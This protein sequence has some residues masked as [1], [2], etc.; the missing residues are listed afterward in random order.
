[1]RT[2]RLLLCLAGFCSI[3]LGGAPQRGVNGPPVQTPDVVPGDC[4]HDI[5]AVSVVWPRDTVALDTV[6]IPHAVIRNFGDQTENNFP[7]VFLIVSGSD[8]LYRA[9]DTVRSAFAPGATRSVTFPAWTARPE[10]NYTAV[11]FTR[12]AD[13][14]D[15]RNDTARACFRVRDCRHD[16]GATLILA[17]VGTVD[18]GTVHTP[19]AVVRNFTTSTETF[20]VTLT[21]DGSYSQTRQVSLPG[22]GVDT[23]EF[24][25]DWTAGPVGTLPVV[26]YTRLA[27]DNNRSND[28]ARA[29]VTVRAC[30]RHDVGTPEILW[31]R[32]PIDSGTV[33]TPRAV[34][35]NYGTSYEEFPVT[36]RIGIVYTRTIST[37]LAA[38]ATD[39]VAFPDWTAHPIGGHTTICYT[40]LGIDEDR[41]NDTAWGGVCVVPLGYH[42]VGTTAILAPAGTVDSGTLHYPTAIIHNYGTRGDSFP[43]TFEIEGGYSAT[44]RRTLLPGQ[45]DTVSFLPYWTARPLGTLA[46]RCYTALAGDANRANDTANGSVTVT[47]PEIHDVGAVLVIA[48]I[49]TV[50]SGSVIAPQALVRNWG[51]RD[52]SFPVTFDIGTGYSRTLQLDL[53][54]GAETTLVFP[55]WTAQPLGTHA[56][57]CYTQLANDVNRA[58]DTARA[59]VDVQTAPRHD[60]GAMTIIA[61]VGLVDSGSAHTPTAVLHNWGNRTENFPATFTLSTGYSQT[62][63]C[64]LEPGQTDTVIFPAWVAAIPGPHACTCYTALAA[65]VDRSNDTAAAAVEVRALP[66]PDVGCEVIL[67][68]TGLV[69]LGQTI[70]PRAIVRHYPDT[71]DATV[72]F[73]VTLTIGTAYR[74]SLVVTMPGGTGR[75]IAFPDWTAGPLG[76]HDV[77]CFTS[78]A[79]DPNR[80]NDTARTAVEV[81]TETH[82]DVGATA[83]LAPEGTLDSG[84][85]HT[86]QAIIRN[87]GTRDEAFPVTFR[88]G[89][90][91]SETLLRQLTPG[92][93]DTVNFPLWIAQPLGRHQTVCFTALD[94]DEDRSNDTVW[95]A[96]SV[97]V[98]RRPRH[99]V[100]ARAITAPSGTV[101]SGA[102]IAPAALVRNWGSEVDSFAVTFIIDT[103]YSRTLGLVLSPGAET[104]LV[105]PDWIA[106]PVDTLEAV[107]FTDLAT[108]EN[109]TNDTARATFEV[110]EPR[111]SDVGATRIVAPTGTVDS[112][113]V[114]SPTVVVRNWGNRNDDF[115]VTFIIGAAYRESLHVSLGRGDSAVVVFPFWIAGPIDSLGIVSYTALDR[116]E[117]R[118]NDTARSF[119]RVVRGERHD[120]GVTEIVAPKGTLDSGTVVSPR[121]VIHNWGYAADSFPVTLRIGGVYTQTRQAT[122]AAGASDTVDFPDWIAQPIGRFQTVA[123]TDLATDENRANDTA[124]GYD[125]VV[126]RAAAVHDVGAL[127]ITRPVGVVDSGRAVT[128]E[129]VIR[130]FGTRTETFPV[131]FTIG[132]GYADTIDCDLEPGETDTVIFE[133]WTADPPGDYGCVCYTALAGDT[134]RHN[135]TATATVTVSPL[136]RPDVG[137]RVILAP[138]GTV[139]LGA[140]VTPQAVV[141]HFVDTDERAEV[142]FPVIMTIGE[143]YRDSTTVTLPAGGIDTVA[144]RDWTAQTMGSFTEVCFTD[145]AGDPNRANDTARGTVEVVAVPYHDVGAEVILAPEGTVH[146][147][148]AIPPRAVVVNLGNQVETF[149]VTLS[150]GAEYQSTVFVESLGLGVYDT[151]TFA[152]W[153]APFTGV[154]AMLCY[155]SLPADENRSNDTVSGTVRVVNAD[156]AAIEIVVPAGT[157]DSGHVLT[158]RA[159]IRNNGPEAAAFP[160]T[161]RIGASWSGSVLADLGAGQSDTFSFPAWTAEPLGVQDAVVFTQLQGDPVPAND[162]ARSQFEVLPATHDVGT[163]AVLEP[164]GSAHLGGPPWRSAVT[165]RAR[166]TN[167]GPRTEALFPARF[168]IDRYEVRSGASPETVFVA[169][170]F[171]E[172]RDVA[173]LEP[174]ESR[175]LAFADTALGLGLYVASCSTRLTG[176]TDPSNDLARE[177]F[178][179]DDSLGTPEFAVRI[180]TRAGELIRQLGLTRQPGDPLW[181]TW[182]GCND[183][184]ERVAPGTYICLMSVQVA[185]G[186]PVETKHNVLVPRDAQ[187]IRLKWRQP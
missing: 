90:G 5:G 80:S 156:A 33:V 101:D 77:V 89:T 84:T 79:A 117:N 139:E 13:D 27:S 103:S 100:G 20:P 144:F 34:I 106:H 4:R 145:L 136:R 166:I 81:V 10:G 11:C 9:T 131:V 171:E 147:G 48:P 114:I 41:S 24:S 82:H 99:D 38:G 160:V 61:P 58:N 151:L 75:T 28:T 87:F 162:T 2:V 59:S 98:V 70:T 146:I 94:I 67:A 178:E 128:P 155:T 125:S 169:T 116:D 154:Q 52:E 130:N 127:S 56:V 83:I 40:R 142:T 174:G 167:H 26:C 32:G 62:I 72:T 44:Q 55:D 86:P 96:D 85:V 25:P 15:R 138:A 165:P 173:A 57:R 143:G 65:D 16:V 148:T 158:P 49:G 68:P 159:I 163:L 122:L 29:T 42:D 120:V 39:T 126:V 73:P 104:T 137:A 78:L 6:G 54:S 88:I 8:T 19:R 164:T 184:G 150:I 113:S 76:A 51:T 186:P 110:R 66:P 176:D 149:P 71:T 91:Y 108:D 187:E 31:P 121:A 118:A 23:V 69:E 140:V 115:P 53:L 182:D 97:T 3:V 181:V 175:E 22:L 124:F 132:S 46:T 60:V 30:P 111:R 134:N 141:R 161:L 109:R 177:I 64:R 107:C 179:V 102:V 1:M 17:P 93:V 180:Y 105:F 92:Q 172:T 43:V 123:F 47:V 12:L 14:A 74:E 133:A 112:G 50:D 168:R 45:T 36:L 37:T 170:V 119:V 135:D 95:G 21:I 153:N 152:T 35:R 185:D 63:Q 7:V 129:A 18:S 157:V 183:R